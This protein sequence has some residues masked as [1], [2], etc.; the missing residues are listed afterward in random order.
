MCIIIDNFLSVR[1]DKIGRQAAACRCPFPVVLLHA[2]KQS[3]CHPIS[4]FLPSVLPSQDRLH[5]TETDWYR[6]M[7]WIMHKARSTEEVEQPYALSSSL[8]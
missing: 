5:A 8:V 4:T 7:F 3:G 2:A 1:I 6:N